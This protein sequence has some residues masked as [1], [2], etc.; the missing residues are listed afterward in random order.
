[1]SRQ[2]HTEFTPNLSLKVRKGFVHMTNGML[3]DH[4]GPFNPPSRSVSW[5]VVVHQTFT[6]KCQG[7]AYNLTTV[8]AHH[9]QVYEGF[10][11]YM[12]TTTVVP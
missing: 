7:Q 8:F 12:T 1:M 3:M 2:K 6:V 5:N 4:V 11:V 10:A 9:M